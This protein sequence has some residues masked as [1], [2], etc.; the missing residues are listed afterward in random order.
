MGI[1]QT[2]NA[3]IGER[4]QRRLTGK[5]KLRGIS[6]DKSNKFANSDV[7]DSPIFDKD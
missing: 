1:G 2:I 6:E 5:I 4:E 7:C 3:G